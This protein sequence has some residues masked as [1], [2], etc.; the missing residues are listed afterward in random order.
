MDAL[1]LDFPESFESDRLTIRAPRPGDGAEINAAV[2]ETSMISMYG[3]RGHN[4][5]PLWRNLNPL[6]AV[7]SVDFW[8][9]RS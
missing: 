3:C 4:R 1:L 6:S 7:H 5:Y 2:R 9:G 8:R